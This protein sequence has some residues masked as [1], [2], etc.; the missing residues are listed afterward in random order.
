MLNCAVQPASALGLL[1]HLGAMQASW[2]LDGRTRTCVRARMRAGGACISGRRRR[3][4]RYCTTC[5]GADSSPFHAISE[6]GRNGW[7]QLSNAAAA[8]LKVPE[9]LLPKK[10]LL[11]PTAGESVQQ[12]P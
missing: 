2:Q 11:G 8:K 10:P 12:V 5:A 1:V 7:R 6:E 3:I 9:A 4:H